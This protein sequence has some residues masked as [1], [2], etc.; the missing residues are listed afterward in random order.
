[1]PSTPP[2][3]RALDPYLWENLT[4]EQ[5]GE[6]AIWV[7]KLLGLIGFG[8]ASWNAA[9]PED[10]EEVAEA[11]AHSSARDRFYLRKL[12]PGCSLHEWLVE[13]RQRDEERARSEWKNLSNE[14]E[15][16]VRAIFDRIGLGKQEWESLG[17]RDQKLI[18]RVA[19]ALVVVEDD[20]EELLLWCKEQRSEPNKTTPRGIME[21]RRVLEDFCDGV[22]GLLHRE[23]KWIAFH[24]ALAHRPE[25]ERILKQHFPRARDRTCED[26]AENEKAFEKKLGNVADELGRLFLPVWQPREQTI[27]ILRDKL[28]EKFPSVAASEILG[29]RLEVS[30]FD[31]RLKRRRA[32]SPGLG[33]RPRLAGGKKPAR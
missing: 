32:K 25:V 24:V 12:R 9:S 33:P 19:T 31:I 8:P 1:M 29:A 28:S 16:E 23:W 6:G 10:R 4:V 27:S 14:T 26:G 20:L 18:K 21:K 15:R 22:L 17:E 5:H 2:K 30:P 7:V 11:V 3:P 13:K